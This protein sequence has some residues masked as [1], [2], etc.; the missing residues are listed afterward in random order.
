MR[1][2]PQV[3]RMIDAER[4]NAVKGLVSSASQTSA[5]MAKTDAT[6]QT[7]PMSLSTMRPTSP[8]RRSSTLSTMPTV[9]ASSDQRKIAFSR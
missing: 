5:G 9:E 4:F 3:R 8:A 7:T 6:A 1:V 2:S